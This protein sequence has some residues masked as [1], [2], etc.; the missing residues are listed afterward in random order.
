MRSP[1]KSVISV[2]AVLAFGVLVTAIL[3]ATK[4]KPEMTPPQMRATPVKV[5]VALSESRQVR[6]EA[7]GTVVPARELDLVPEVSG[8]IVE[9]NPKLVP[10]G[11]LAEGETIAK[12]DQRDYQ[13]A[14]NQAWAGVKEARSGLELEKGRQ[15]VAKKEWELMSDTRSK[16]RSHSDL[17]LRK[18]QL[19]NAL[20]RLSS[21]RSAY[22]QAKRNLERCVLHSPMNAIVNMEAAEVGQL[23]G[24]QTRLAVLVGAD[25]YRI[26]VSIPVSRLPWIRLPDEEGGSGARAEIIHEAGQGVTIRRQGR[27]IRLLGSLETA[28]RMARLLVEVDDPLGRGSAKD[29][30]GLPL[31]IDAYVRVEMDGPQLDGVFVIPRTAIREG[32]RIWIMDNDNKL[33]IRK[34]EIIWRR[35]NDVY[36]KEGIKDGE[37]IVTSNIPTPIPGLWLRADN[38]DS[39]SPVK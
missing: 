7:M 14:L 13:T 30:T 9:L 38:N 4:H 15:V 5:M 20:A 32:D 11:Y 27:V 18:P 39:S 12:I 34:L 25:K 3:I 21:A 8:R 35:E 29:E 26:R 23:V 33:E 37:Y 28:G 22:A 2:A 1:L 31:L 17:A 16:G 6:I 36:V 24:P 10:G 19:A